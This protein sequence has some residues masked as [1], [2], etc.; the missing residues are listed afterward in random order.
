MRGCAA[1]LIVVRREHS[2]QQKSDRKNFFVSGVV[3]AFGRAGGGN[4]WVRLGPRDLPVPPAD[5]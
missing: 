3:Q 2:G 4:Q 5:Q 1:K